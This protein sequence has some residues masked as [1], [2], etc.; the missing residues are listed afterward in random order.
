MLMNSSNDAPSKPR[1][2]F[3]AI[4]ATKHWDTCRAS[5]VPMPLKVRP[6]ITIAKAFGPLAAPISS[7]ATVQMKLESR[8]SLFLPR[9]SAARPLSRLARAVTM[10]RLPTNTETCHGLR[11]RSSAMSLFADDII[12]MS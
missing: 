10:L 7:T 12:P 9:V 5:P 4:S 8:M 2:C 6:S 3:G 11:S 1:I